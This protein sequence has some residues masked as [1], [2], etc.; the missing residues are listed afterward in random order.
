[1]EWYYWVLIVLGVVGIGYLKLLFFKKMK[2]NAAK[3]QTY[4]EED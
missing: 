4:K 2:D 3:K 1:M